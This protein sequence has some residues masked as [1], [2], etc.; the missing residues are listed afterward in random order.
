M[1]LCLIPEQEFDKTMFQRSR[2]NIV[3]DFSFIFEQ[4]PFKTNTVME[5]LKT[6]LD[7]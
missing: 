6:E 1:V 2:Y 7:N 4:E 3:M 5:Y